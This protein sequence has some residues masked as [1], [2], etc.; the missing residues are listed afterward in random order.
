MVPKTKDDNEF[1]SL[2]LEI[3]KTLLGKWFATES[4]LFY[5]SWEFQ[6][7]SNDR[8]HIN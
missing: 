2:K 4:P 1:D 5:V 3:Y 8:K 6:F 7:L